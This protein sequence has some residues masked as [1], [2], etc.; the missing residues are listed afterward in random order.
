VR[1]LLSERADHDLIILPGTCLG[2]LGVALARTATSRPATAILGWRR[3]AR[4]S[5]IRR[6]ARRL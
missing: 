3:V 5:H 6:A 4:F 2:G 1:D